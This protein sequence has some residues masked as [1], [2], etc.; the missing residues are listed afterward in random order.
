MQQPCSM[1]S[2]AQVLTN[3]PMAVSAVTAATLVALAPAPAAAAAGAAAAIAA[4]CCTLMLLLL[5]MPLLMLLQLQVG[6]FAFVSPCLCLQ[7]LTRGWGIPW[8]CV[9]CSCP[10]DM[11]MNQAAW[12]GVDTA[13]SPEPCP[14]LHDTH[15]IPLL[16]HIQEP[17]RNL[18]IN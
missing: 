18:H 9:T 13:G 8:V 1:R 4:A 16:T 12:A 7:V 10:R 3:Q 15:T 5:W 17:R 6:T 14:T 2:L 11:Y